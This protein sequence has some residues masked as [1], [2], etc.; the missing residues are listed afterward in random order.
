MSLL[1]VSSGNGGAAL[2]AASTAS[3]SMRVKVL[4]SNSGS[5]VDVTD[6]WATGPKMQLKDSLI[7]VDSKRTIIFSQGLQHHHKALSIVGDISC[8]SPAVSEVTCETFVILNARLS[9]D[10]LIAGD[11]RETV[12]VIQP[13]QSERPSV[14]S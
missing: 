11:L 8:L 3:L 7:V 9:E 13:M 2:R 4:Q 6:E 1:R 10:Y 14:G 5:I 12:S